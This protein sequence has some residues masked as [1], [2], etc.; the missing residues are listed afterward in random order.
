MNKIKLVEIKNALNDNGACNILTKKNTGIGG[1][2]Y[3][4]FF[5]DIETYLLKIK[6]L[7]ADPNI[8]IDLLL[9]PNSGRASIGSSNPQ[10]RLHINLEAENSKLR[11]NSRNII[12][13]L[14]YPLELGLHKIIPDAIKDINMVFEYHD[15]ALIELD[16]EYEDN[17]DIYFGLPEDFLPNPDG[18]RSM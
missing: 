7:T 9:E 14:Q 11:S 3:L 15:I 13:Y 8:S 12:K 5:I 6:L 16:L 18:S 10:Q 4:K 2:L 1:Y 17:N